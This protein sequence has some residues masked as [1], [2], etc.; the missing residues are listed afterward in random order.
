[1]MAD[2][3]SWEDGKGTRRI[4]FDRTFGG[5]VSLL[6]RYGY[7][8]YGEGMIH[9]QCS[10]ALFEFCGPRR[11][12]GGKT[13]GDEAGNDS[14]LPRS[15]KLTYIPAGEPVRALEHRGLGPTQC[16]ADAEGEG[17]LGMAMLGVEQLLGGEEIQS[18][19][20]PGESLHSRFCIV[21]LES[22]KKT[23]IESTLFMGYLSPDHGAHRCFAEQLRAIGSGGGE[24]GELG[25]LPSVT[26][27]WDLQTDEPMQ[28]D[29]LRR[30]IGPKFFQSCS[31]AWRAKK[32]AKDMSLW[33]GGVMT[34]PL[35]LSMYLRKLPKPVGRLM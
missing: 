2:S 4:L 29:I 30:A 21:G 3:T 1:M 22:P 27:D 8:K 12:G 9:A 33:P 15:I 10:H 19:L 32:K 17:S 5:A 18:C 16:Q 7:T 14:E 11:D 35:A 25:N 13:A 34:P 28:K 6:L 20:D 23:T 26:V 24:I 31:L